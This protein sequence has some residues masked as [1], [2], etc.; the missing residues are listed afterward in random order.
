MNMFEEMQESRD[1]G[2]LPNYLHLK[3][4]YNHELK[5]FYVLYRVSLT[6]FQAFTCDGKHRLWFK[7]KKTEVVAQLLEDGPLLFMDNTGIGSV[8]H[9]GP[10]PVIIDTYWAEPE[11]EPG[12]YISP[13]VVCIRTDHLPK[14]AGRNTL[15]VYIDDDENPVYDN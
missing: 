1:A 3:T 9:N 6:E 7:P 12:V 4:F 2:D 15:C 14:S 8:H 10:P 13:A 11:D 5:K